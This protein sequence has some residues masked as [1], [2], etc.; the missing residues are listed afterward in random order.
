MPRAS[1]L[2]LLLVVMGCAHTVP[3]DPET[4]DGRASVNERADRQRATITRHDG[5]HHLAEALRVDADSTFWFEPGTWEFFSI[6][7][8]D[9]ASIAFPAEGGGAAE[10]FALGLAGGIL[11]GYVVGTRSYEGKSL[12]SQSRGENAMGGA[13][14]FGG[15]GALIGLLIGHDTERTDVFMPENPQPEEITP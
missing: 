4:P 15:A 5:R 10:G 1:S 14:L 7:T 2:L 11:L 3:F 12:L 6:P 9:V 8:G 13:L